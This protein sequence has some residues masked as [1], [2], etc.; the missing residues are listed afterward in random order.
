MFSFFLDSLRAFISKQQNWRRKTNLEN[1]D[2][3]EKLCGATDESQIQMDVITK[4]IQSLEM[5]VECFFPEQSQEHEALVRK[6]FCTELDV[7]SMMAISQ[8]ISKMN[9]WI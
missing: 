5:E 3:F 6:P 1:I 7:S 4:H 2:M 9:F 8:I